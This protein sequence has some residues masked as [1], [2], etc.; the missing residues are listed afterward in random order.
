MRQLANPAGNDHA[1][2]AGESGAAAFAFVNEVLSNPD[3][4]DLRNTLGLD[5]DSQIIVIN[6]EGATDP[7]NY[8]RIINAN[9]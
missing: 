4:R 9:K 6:T 2:V 5:E 3:Y 1:I 8:Q 7:V